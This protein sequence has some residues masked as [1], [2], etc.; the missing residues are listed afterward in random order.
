MSNEIKPVGIKDVARLAGVSTST[1]SNVL[2]GTKPVSEALHQKVMQ[3][4]NELHYEVNMVARGL[5]SGKTNNI[6]VIVSSITSVFFPPLL[7]SIQTAANQHGYTVSVFATD[8]DLEKE[9][10]FIHMLKTQWIDG[11]LLSSCVD[12]SS[13]KC[14]SYIQELS[15]L[16]INGHPIPLICL[17]SEV[18]PLLDAVVVDD[19]AGI[20]DAVRHL[21]EIGRKNIAYISFPETYTMGKLR[22]KGY[23]NTLRELDLKM[24]KKI[25][26]EG[27]CDPQSGYDCMKS[28]LNSGEPVDAV[29]AGND[30]MAIGAMRAVMDAGLR[31]PQDIAIV[32]YDDNFPASLVQ[33]STI[34]V[35]KEDLGKSAF[36]LFLRRTQSPDASRMLMRLNGELIIRNSTVLGAESAWELKNW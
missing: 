36:D 25:I 28:I 17:E 29:I 8:G 10:H 9:K 24:N 11:I 16:K 7:Q 3:A 35:P 32:G 13:R 6:A 4:V 15:S 31:I 30:Q 22:R 1:V 12:I 34:R 18:G 19:Q 21:Y 20:S 26:A 33:L 27:A 14:A 2:N 23:E 5:K